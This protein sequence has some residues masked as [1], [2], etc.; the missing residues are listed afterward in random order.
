MSEQICVAVY[1]SQ[2]FGDDK[3]CST[4]Y[5]GTLKQIIAAMENDDEYKCNY[6]FYS[7]G[8]DKLKLVT[9]YS[10]EKVV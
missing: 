7:L 10:V 4:S 1:Q 5:V 2:K 9:E 6:D 8:A 3:S